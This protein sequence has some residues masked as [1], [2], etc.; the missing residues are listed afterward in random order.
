MRKRVRG[1]SLCRAR[2][3]YGSQK[4]ADRVDGPH[5]AGCS[6]RDR[7]VFVDLR[8]QP[9]GGASVGIVIKPERASAISAGRGK[10]LHR[11][12]AGRTS[13]AAN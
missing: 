1:L 9:G 6:L 11:P 2:Q 10:V 4:R 13:F 3:G 5:L 7:K 12:A 8:Q